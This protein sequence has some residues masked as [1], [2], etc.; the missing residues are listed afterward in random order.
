MKTLEE[1]YQESLDYLYSFVDYSLTR[2][3]QFSEENFDLSRM[4][5]L[6]AKM[7]NPEKQF[8]SIHVA[9]TKGKGSTAALIAGAIH[10]EGNT[11]GFYTSPHLVDFSERIQVNGQSIP[12]EQL[13]ALLDKM[14]P[15][16]DSVQ[17]LTTFEITT[18]LAFQYFACRKADYAVVEVGLGGRLDATNVIDPMISVITSISYDHM[19]VLGNTLTK[20]AGEKAGIIKTR[21]PVV[22]APQ[23][24]EA[25]L[26]LLRAAEEN[27]SSLTMVGRDYFFCGS[28]HNLD[29]QTLQVWKASDQPK[30][31]LYIEENDQSWQPVTLTIPLLGYHQIV[32]AATAYAALD[33]ARLEGL[34]TGDESI[35]KG[36]DK[37]V[38]PG[39]F[40]V[41]S[42]LPPVIIDSAHNRDS[43]LKLRLALD[44]YLPGMPVILIFGASEDKDVTGMFMELLPRVSRIIATQSTHP[45]AMD[46]NILV[47]LAHQF[48][49]PAEAVVPVEEALK[50]GL[51]LAEGDEKGSAVVTAGSLFAAAAV[52]DIWFR[53]KK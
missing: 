15:A 42:K 13:V 37:V 38:W 25:L 23:S 22:V 21:R 5:A 17:R 9:G 4:W 48:G 3:L 39:R 52:R 44:D 30:M 34:V 10:E 12:A 6:L 7:G 50:I 33:T 53:N 32:N 46:A 20:I 24:E 29:R 41:L 36:F 19:G 35:R 47:E 11:V 43:A 27:Q 2:N 1:K 49:C 16:I 31:N 18:A 26:P 40:E 51:Q 28:D 8:K 45:R 14:K